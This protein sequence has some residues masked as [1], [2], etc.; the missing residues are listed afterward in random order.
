MTQS[1]VT[2]LAEDGTAREGRATVQPISPGG[3]TARTLGYVLGGLLGG[4]A[5]IIIP[6]LHL[7]TTWALPLIGILAGLRA[8]RARADVR[9]VQG[10]CPACG[11]P[12]E[13]GGGCV[14]EE[15]LSTSCPS[16][17]APLRVRVDGF[18]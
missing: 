1:P 18:A 17:Q 4:A 15:P 11:E 14:S 5:C 16:C 13:L 3:R 2:L 7:I 6:V 12:I 8:W 10:P 9:D